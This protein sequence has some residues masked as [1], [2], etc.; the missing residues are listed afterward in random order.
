MAA[1][2]K[3][4]ENALVEAGRD[5]SAA[6]GPSG[7]GSGLAAAAPRNS[8]GSF[9]DESCS[10]NDPTTDGCITA[11][12]L[13]AYNQ[14]RRF[15]FTRFTSC[16]RDGGSGE[17][18]LGRACDFAAEPNGFGGVATGG[19]RR[20]GDNLANFFIRNA[21]RLGVHVRDLVP[22]DLVA[23]QRLAGVPQ[24][25]WRPG[26]ANT[27]TTYT[28]RSS[29]PARRR[30]SCAGGR[31]V[32]DGAQAEEALCSI[33]CPGWRSKRRTTSWRSS[34]GTCRACAATPRWSSATA[35]TPTSSIPTCWRTSPPGGR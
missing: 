25:Q 29:R 27:R 24:R 16:K 7:G 33:S 9:S 19:D 26:A 34:S 23:Q 12:T 35:G 28:C 22:A 8:D 3:Q 2:K 17:H 15:G 32:K 1:R 13:H 14:A 11:R 31:R 4:A 5:G 30:R 21:D 20:Y 18:P 6:G 10:R